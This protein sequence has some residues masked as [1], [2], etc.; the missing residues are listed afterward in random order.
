[1]HD[2]KKLKHLLNYLKGTATWKHSP[3]PIR[4]NNHKIPLQQ[5]QKHCTSAASCAHNT[6]NQDAH[7]H[8]QLRQG[9]PKKAKHIELK[10]LF[11]QRSVQEG[12]ISVLKIRTDNNP[13][14]HLHQV[15]HSRNSQPFTGL[16]F[17]AIPRSNSA[18][19]SLTSVSP[20]TTGAHGPCR[21]T[22]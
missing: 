18:T 12:I 21:C 20:V 5:R 16:V 4:L 19:N 14:W 8:R 2:D 15:H 13:L 17:L 3:Q 10:Y 9:S 11:I 1:M 7:V 6:E 22:M